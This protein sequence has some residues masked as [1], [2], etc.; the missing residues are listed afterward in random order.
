MQAIGLQLD[1]DPSTV[2]AYLNQYASDFRSENVE[3]IRLQHQDILRMHA[4]ALK[5]LLSMDGLGVGST[6][7]AIREYRNTLESDRKLMGIDL[8]AAA[9]RPDDGEALEK[10]QAEQD[11]EALIQEQRDKNKVTEAQL[12]SIGIEPP[13]SEPE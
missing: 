9:A 8:P 12:R 6:L 10:T 3:A 1:L 2:R 13:S 4:R 11:L 5:R 7:A